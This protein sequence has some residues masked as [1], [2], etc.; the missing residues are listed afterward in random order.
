ME[1]KRAVEDGPVEDIFLAASIVGMSTVTN[2][3]HK[4]L[5]T[6]VMHNF[7]LISGGVDDFFGL[8]VG[9]TVRLGIDYG[10][11]DK[12]D[13]GIGR[14]SQ[15]NNVDVRLKYLV[16][17]QL[18]SDKV[19]VQ[20]ALKANVG[21]NTQKE[22]RFDFTFQ[23][24]LNYLGSVM[25][26]RKFTDQFSLQITPMISHFNTTVIEVENEEQNHTLFA[27]GLGTRYKWNNRNAL[28][29]EYLPVLGNRNSGTTNHAALSLEIDTGG[30]VFQI[31]LMSGQ[32]FTEQHLLARTNTDITDLDFR[33][34]FN[35]NRLFSL[36][37]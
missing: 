22:N 2:L 18:Q 16:L 36:G 24:R 9:A 4:N 26:A 13:I 31:F 30:H 37:D 6:T 21:V 14:T 7:G 35:I 8:D 28:A 5:N 20:I 27:V 11:T 15:E 17:Q 33:I 34:G 29:F 12:L 1:R 23:E 25:I 32:W 3:P 10:L 19:P